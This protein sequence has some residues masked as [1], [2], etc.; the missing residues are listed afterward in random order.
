MKLTSNK[1]SLFLGA[2]CLLALVGYLPVQRH[3]DWQSTIM[4]PKTMQPDSIKGKDVEGTELTIIEGERALKLK[5]T[6]VELDPQDPTHETY[7]YTLLAFNPIELKWQNYCQPDRNQVA[8]AI[9]LSGHWNATGTHIP[10]QQITFACTNGVLAKCVRLGYK[11][12]KSIGGRSLRD[13]HQ[14]CTRMLRADYCGNGHSHTKDGT[15]VDIYDHLGI[16]TRTANSKMT[17]EAG[18]RPDGAVDIARTRWLES[19][20]QIQKECPERIKHP[21]SSHPAPNPQQAPKALLFNDS[22]NQVS[23]VRPVR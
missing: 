9:P 13:Y 17:F 14:A 11:P 20:A 15:L 18:W 2:G 8:K 5:I 3:L 10:S 6:Q 19:F 7:L 23:L 21:D 4:Q 16:Q 12:W 22:L 1:L